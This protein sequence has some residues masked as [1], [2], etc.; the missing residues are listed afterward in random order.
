MEHAGIEVL[1]GCTMGHTADACLPQRPI[2][3]PFREDCIDGRVMDGW[4][5]TGFCRYGQA[6]PLPPRREAPHT[7]GP[8]AGRAQCA[9]ETSPGH[10]EVREDTYRELL[11]RRVGQASASLQALG[12]LSSLGKGLTQDMWTRARALKRF[13]D[14][15]RCGCFTILATRDNCQKNERNGNVYQ[16]NHAY[17]SSPGLCRL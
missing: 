13:R 7:A 4:A 14:D 17:Q 11:G 12:L 8:D 16:R 6:L 3:G 1:R 2:S 5:A 10:R 9:R 15:K